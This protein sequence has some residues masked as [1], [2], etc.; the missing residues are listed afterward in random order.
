VGEIGAD[1]D[2]QRQQRLGQPRLVT[3][4]LGPQNFTALRIDD[5]GLDGRGSDIDTED[6]LI[7]GEPVVR[8]QQRQRSTNPE[9][10]LP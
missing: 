3:P 9:G 4:V 7:A 6:D 5:D 1:V 2:Q 8:E 10:L